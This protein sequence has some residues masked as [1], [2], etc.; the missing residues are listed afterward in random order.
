MTIKTPKK[1]IT[2]PTVSRP[3]V[4]SRGSGT[5]DAILKAALRILIDEGVA[6]FTLR[7]IAQECDL[8]VGNVS[9]HFPR[10]EML[11][12]VLLEELLQPTDSRIE[13]NIRKTGMA[14]EDAL[15]L[16]I[17]G[18]MDEIKSKKYT[19]L[20]IELW[21]MANH[22]EFVADRVE[23]LYRYMMNLVVGYVLEMNPDLS[24]EEAQAVALYI[25]ATVEGT[26]MLSGYAKPWADMMPQMQALAIRT[27]IELV[28]TIK[29]GELDQ[30][31]QSLVD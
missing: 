18:T 17:R 30:L 4:Y 8:K 16:I 24:I 25:N 9:R 6:A 23:N 13:Q 29:P 28:K 7:R 3:G 2:A 1:P 10:K 14:P 12:Q 20:F 11:V 15:I 5:V 22:N 19:N 27:L 26:T 21:A 31:T